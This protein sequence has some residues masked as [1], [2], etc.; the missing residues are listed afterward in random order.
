M[1]KPLTS[2]GRWRRRVSARIR[3]DVI[4]NSAV[5]SARRS[6]LQQRLRPYRVRRRSDS[7]AERCQRRVERGQASSEGNPGIRTKV[8]RRGGPCH[9]R[10]R[11]VRPATGVSTTA[12]EPFQRRLRQLGRRCT[13]SR[14]AAWE[15]FM[16]LMMLMM[17]MQ[18][19]AGGSRSLAPF[20]RRPRRSFG[21]GGRRAGRFEPW[22]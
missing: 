14:A 3:S 15:S 19:Q 22:R 9:R 4:M 18:R 5:R 21:W 16:M 8:R 7:T 20:R 11:R 17:L 13:L 1:P 10:H 2:A 12:V 6:V